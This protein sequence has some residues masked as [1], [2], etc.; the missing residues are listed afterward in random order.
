MNSQLPAERFDELRRAIHAHLKRGNVY[1]QVR[2]FVREFVQEREASSGTVISEDELV[3]VLHE[4]DVIRTVLRGLSTSPSYP[5]VR[6]V[7]AAASGHSGRMLHVRVCSARAFVDLADEEALSGCTFQVIRLLICARN[8]IQSLITALQIHCCLNSQRGCSRPV[9]A[10]SDPAVDDSVLFT[11]PDVGDPLLL[12]DTLDLL[13]MAAVLNRP[14]GSSQL[15][16]ANAID[17]RKCLIRQVALCRLDCHSSFTPSPSFF[18]VWS[19]TVELRAFDGTSVPAGI[20]EVSVEMLPRGGSFSIEDKLARRIALVRDGV[21]AADR[22][23]FNYAK[24]WWQEY[25]SVGVHVNH[26]LIK[27]LAQA[28]DGSSR[29]VCSFLQPIQAR[30][31]LLSAGEAARFVSSISTVRHDA[32]AGSKSD[33]WLSLHSVLASRSGDIEAHAVLL[34]SIFLGLELD[35]YVVLGHTASD[36]PHMWVMTLGDSDA[37]GTKCFHTFPACLFL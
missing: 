5:S 33:V 27:L 17:W 12:A 10:S 13:H 18:Q 16:G 36:E 22:S 32:V 3:R 8:P 25:L 2:S 28:E 11:L 9:T 34:C 23:Y 24:K 29:C 6:A 19:A 21:A 20:V 1:D 26:R 35:A 7:S 14:G 31:A 15:I 30:H 37:A 4:K